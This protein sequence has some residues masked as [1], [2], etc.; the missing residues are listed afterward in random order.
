MERISILGIAAI[1]MAAFSCSGSKGESR[2]F[3]SSS[4]GKITCDSIA[5]EQILQPVKWTLVDGKAIIF[6][7]KS[8]NVFYIYRLPD[9]KYL[10]S[11]GSKGEGPE[12]F[13][14]PEF[15]ADPGKGRMV[16]S[17]KR[18]ILTV[19][20]KEKG[21]GEVDHLK[22]REHL[23]QPKMIVNDSIV[24]GYDGYLTEEKRI[25]NY[26][27]TTNVNLAQGGEIIDS[28]AVVVYNKELIVRETKNGLYA[29]GRL[30]NVPIL[31]P[32]KD[33]FVAAY[34]DICNMDFYK[35]SPQGKITYVRTVGQRISQQEI[36]ALDLSKREVGKEIA[37]VQ[38]GKKYLYVFV[39]DYRLTPEW[40]KLLNSYME[41]YDLKGNRVKKFD[42]GR[43][44]TRFL[45]DEARGKIYCY[46]SGYDFENVYIY[47]YSL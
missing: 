35:V 6:S 9:F 4:I 30:L 8:D 32:L 12:D 41:V 18:H 7:P 33:G 15:L 47:D 27:Y 5:I 14:Y 26:Y 43:P 40:R 10:Y 44:F 21:P 2:S 37:Q 39:N 42:L 23:Y 34:P 16:V 17:D 11:F 29:S 46:H 13:R 24:V 45:I 20:L 3:E 31:A 22:T 38:A 28:V 1:A 36:N 19:A 25:N